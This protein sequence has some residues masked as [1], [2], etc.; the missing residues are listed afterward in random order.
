MKYIRKVTLENFQSHKFSIIELNEQM[1]VIVGPSDSGKSAIIRGIKW[2][3]YNEPAGDYFIREGEKDCRVTLEFNDNTILKR[4]RSKSRNSYILINKNGEEMKFEGFGSYIPTEIVDSIG[5]KKIYLDSDESNAINIGEQLDGA[6]LLSEKTST[7]ASAIGR[8]VGV[9]IID[10]ALREVLKDTRGLNISKKALE[11]SS[12]KISN[13]LSSFDHL[14]ALKI[15]LNKL[16]ELKSNIKS[17][18][19]KLEKIIFNKSRLLEVTKEINDTSQIIGVLKIVDKLN[20]L[21]N[22]IDSK[23]LKYK[24]LNNYNT[25]LN[26]INIGIKENTIIASKLSNLDDSYNKISKIEELNIIY[27]ILNVL[28]K[29][30][31]LNLKEK[32]SLDIIL[33]KLVSLDTVS[34]DL[35]EISNKYTRLIKLEHNNLKYKNI[36]DSINIGKK[37]INNLSGLEKIEPLAKII[38][39]KTQLLNYLNNIYTIL[40]TNSKESQKELN[41]LTQ[42]NST[43][44]KQ[45]NDYQKLLRKIEI[46]PFCLSEIDEHKIEHIISHY[47]GG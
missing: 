44:E 19:T 1:N 32:S 41:S 33:S 8:L 46:C 34:N 38:N 3:L 7:R 29:K 30:H 11:E 12:T 6:F 39:S 47:I 31:N 18:Q 14:D 10:D 13:E 45:L 22:I 2:A 24:Y 5:I 17:K 15:K 43:I 20:E 26:K 23:A 21:I 35:F 28:Q 4:Y 16:V 42:I 37:Y 25:N 36:N 40:L 27:C 9:N